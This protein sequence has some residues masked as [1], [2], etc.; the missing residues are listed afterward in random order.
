MM[1]EKYHRFEY[2]DLRTTTATTQEYSQ[3]KPR[4]LSVLGLTSGMSEGDPGAEEEETRLGTWA[5]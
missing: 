3:H 2:G 5:W 1:K 4:A